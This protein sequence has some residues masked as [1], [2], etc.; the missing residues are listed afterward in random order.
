MF[1]MLLLFEEIITF[2]SYSLIVIP[3]LISPAAVYALQGIFSY[4]SSQ[5]ALVSQQALISVYDVIL[6]VELILQ[7]ASILSTK[8]TNYSI[9]SNHQNTSKIDSASCTLLTIYSV[10]TQNCENQ[11]C[12]CH[13]MEGDVQDDEKKL[14][15]KGKIIPEKMWYLFAKQVLNDIINKRN[16]EA[17]LYITL[18]SIE[19]LY[20]KN[21]LM[22]L[23]ILSKAEEI[24][25]SIQITISILYKRRLI[26]DCMLEKKMDILRDIDSSRIIDVRR[27]NKFMQLYNVFIEEIEACTANNLAFWTI[28]LEEI[29]D[30]SRLNKVGSNISTFLK[31]IHTLYFKIMEADSSNMQFLFQYGVFLRYIV[32]DELTANTIFSK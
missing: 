19:H 29:P 30:T 4:K 12:I 2:Q 20:L 6:Y 3:L 5:I 27:M 14:F 25:P 32:F 10:H 21:E 11:E 28:L 18:A 23:C 15:K 22:A 31:K 24:K 8:S 1:N 26:E 17:E 7:S 13:K 16:K 9:N